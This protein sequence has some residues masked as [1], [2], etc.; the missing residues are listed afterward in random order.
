MLEFE[1]AVL[2]NG[3]R[4]IH[5]RVGGPVAHC[6]LIINTGS[7]DE[8]EKEEGIAHFI[9]HVI[10]KGTKK[11]KAYHILSRMEDVG[12]EINAYTG[13]E[14]TTL[15][16]SFMK[17]DYERAIELLSDITFNSTFPTKELEKEKAV[18]IDEINSYE[19]SPA[20][21]I[22]DHFEELLFPDHP[23]GRNILGS[24]KKVQGFNSDDIHRFI[25][26]NYHTHDMVFSSVGD[27]PME[28]LLYFLE[29]YLGELNIPKSAKRRQDVGAY[30]PKTRKVKR[31]TY[32]THVIMGGRSLPADD[33]RS[34]AMVLL[35]NLLGG[36]GMNSRLNLAIRERYG[37]CYNIESFYHPYSDT[38]VF[39][40]YFSTDKGTADKSIHLV[41]KELKLLREKKLG[42]QQL[43]RAKKQLIGQINIGMESRLNLMLSFGRSMLMFDRVDTVSEVVRKVEGLRAEDIQELAQD[44]LNEKAMCSITYQAR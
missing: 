13:K 11:R 17:N 28:K 36:P 43:S 4:V 3:I 15:H 32:Q 6:G 23:L 22:F 29:K 42:V 30:K 34:T 44:Q 40:I 2:S 26:R 7:R 25:D 21:L 19:D 41:Q 35:N 9:E 8:S 37:F 14:D 39:G 18:I 12:G 10:F 27:I 24:P 1:R 38:G 31:D 33:D 16:A 5:K 20:E